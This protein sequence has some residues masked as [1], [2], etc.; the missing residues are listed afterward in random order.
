MNPASKSFPVQVSSFI[1]TDI[2]LKDCLATA[3]PGAAH[4]NDIWVK[5]VLQQDNQ[6]Q[7][8]TLQTEDLLKDY[9]RFKASGINFT[10]TPVYSEEGLYAEFS[11]PFGNDYILMEKRNYNED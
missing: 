4:E 1:D 5:R 2:F 3:L 6:M 8:I 9:C 11:D 10:Q 7:K